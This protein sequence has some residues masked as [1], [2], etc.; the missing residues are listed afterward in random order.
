MNGCTIPYTP[1][2][3]DFWKPRKCSKISVFFLSHVQ[4]DKSCGLSS[5]WVLPI[6]CSPVSKKLLIHLF[7]VRISI[8]ANFVV[9]GLSL[10]DVP[11]RLSFI[12]TM[13][14]TYGWILMRM[15][16]DN[17]LDDRPW[18]EEDWLTFVEMLLRSSC[19]LPEICRIPDFAKFI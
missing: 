12:Y 17:F 3:V 10:T 16:T 5:K 14:K 2:A 4:L 6:Y 11:V 1:I 8:S 18:H 19:Q 9:K 13:S 7:Q 15:R